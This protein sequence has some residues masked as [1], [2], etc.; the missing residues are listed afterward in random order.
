MARGRGGGEK[1][2][3]DGIENVHRTPDARGGKARGDA[4][5]DARDDMPDA[6]EG[7][8]RGDARDDMPDARGG[9]ARGDARDDTPDARG[10][11]NVT[12]AAGLR[13]GRRDVLAVFASRTALFAVRIVTQALFAYSLGPD[14]R[15]TLALC[16]AFGVI[17]GL[18]FTPGADRGAQHAVASRR[19]SVS[20]GVWAAFAICLVGS[21]A[22]VALAMPLIWGGF[23]FFGDSDA[24]AFYAAMALIPTWSLS[25]AIEMQL[26][27]MRRF[28]MVALATALES[29][30]LMAGAALLVWALDLGVIG[31]I[32]AYALAHILSSA[33]R[34]WDLRRRCGLRFEPPSAAELRR[35]IV[36]G[37]KYHIAQLGVAVE[38]RIESVLLGLVAARAEVGLMS[39]AYMTLARISIIPHS[40]A[41]IIQPRVAGAADGAPRLVAFCARLATLAAAAA[42]AAAAV[43]AEPIVQL[44]HSSAFLDAIPLLRIL[45]PGIVFA[46]FAD[47]LMCYF[48]GVDKPAVCSRATFIG[49]AATVAA[50]FAL[51]HYANMVA[52]AMAWALAIGFCVRALYLAAL[53]HKYSGMSPLAAW[54][55]KRSDAAYLWSA[56]GYVAREIRRRGRGKG[57]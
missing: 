41:T 57:G 52:A 42:I 50:F 9:K 45:A 40:I 14:G 47:I 32:A 16:L 54:I 30:S 13:T 2:A 8:S 48:R 56:A 6:R 44:L 33:L 11:K 37:L 22:A 53:F 12:E 28:Y 25:K 27:A 15:G 36:Y 21:A 55:P 24:P 7:K 49:M 4:P 38:V 3:D 18:A 43:G 20:Q 23:A 29:L 10:G 46:V 19:A 26:A 39:A 1:R 35:I 51:F 5:G 31:A 34:L 17:S